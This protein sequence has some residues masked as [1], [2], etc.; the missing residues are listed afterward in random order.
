MSEAPE[1][2]ESFQTFWKPIICPNGELDLE[3][4]KKELFDY[5]NIMMEVSKVDDEITGGRISKPNTRA[6]AVIAVYEDRVNELIEEALK[7]AKQRP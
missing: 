3:Q 2:E 4:V 7:D 6:D 5:H 1:V